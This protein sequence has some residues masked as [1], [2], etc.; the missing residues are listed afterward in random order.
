MTQPDEPCL[1]GEIL[2]DIE[3]LTIYPATHYVTTEERMRYAITGIEQELQE[4][5]AWLD[6]ENKLLESQRLRMRARF[7]RSAATRSA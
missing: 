2:E 7:S 1:T 3:D 6:G 4:R 5:L